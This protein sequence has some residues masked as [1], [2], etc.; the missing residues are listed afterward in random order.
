MTELHVIAPY[1][2]RGVW[3]F[4]D[5]TAG[6]VKEPF[7]N[8][9]DTMIDAMTSSIPEAGRGFTMIFS[10]DPFSGYQYRF[11]RRRTEGAETIY[12]SPNFDVE[13][14]LSP[15]VLRYFDAPPSEVFV[16]I[17]AMEQKDAN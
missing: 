12:Y 8:G 7:V 13:G 9:A 4:D 16:Q 17:R 3:V 15:A 6:L 11:L 2:H 1:R 10:A 14:S 5:S